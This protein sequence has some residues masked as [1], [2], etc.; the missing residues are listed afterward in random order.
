M[1]LTKEKQKRRG[2]G[3]KAVTMTTTTTKKK[4]K[5]TV[6]KKLYIKICLA[7]DYLGVLVNS[8]KRVRAFQ[9]EL[10]FGSVGFQVQVFSPGR[11]LYK[12]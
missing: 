1:K 2:E 4:D 7:T 9:M 11:E 10:E 5:K 8:L 3:K 12:F 6:L